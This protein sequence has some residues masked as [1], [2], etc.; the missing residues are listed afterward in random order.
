MKNRIQHSCSL[1]RPTVLALAIATGFP[2]AVSAQ[3][4]LPD[5]FSVI[6]S[7]G[8]D[9]IRL[10]GYY[11]NRVIS[12]D[13]T[14]VIG[15]GRTVDGYYNAFRWTAADG[16]ASLGTLGGNYSYAHSMSA[17]GGVVVG[18]SYL[19]D[20]GQYRA[21]R[22][23]ETA[24]MVDLGTLGGNYS[25]AYGV[26][27][28]GGTVVGE[29][30]IASGH[31]RAFRWTET[32]GMVSL[33]TLGGDYSYAISVSDD[34]NAVAG[35]AHTDVGHG[36]AFRWTEAG[37]MADL[38]TLGGNYSYAYGISGD[39]S[40]VVG[41]SNTE[42][43][44][45]NAFRWT[46]A[47]GMANLGT[48]GGNY[49]YAY[50]VNTDGSVVIGY[51]RT[52]EDNYHAFRWT[53][54]GGMADLGT[55]GGNYSWAS[56]LSDDGS[57]VVGV[58]HDADSQIQPFRWTESTG[59]QSVTD[60]LAGAGVTTPEGWMLADGGEV[61]VNSLGNVLVGT[62]RDA[63][64]NSQVWLA[65]VGHGSGIISVS[66]WLRSVT[67]AGQ[68]FHSGFQLTN[69]PLNGAHHRPLMS[70]PQLGT[71]HCFWAT[72][73]LAYHDNKD[74]QVGTGEIGV[75]TDL[76]GGTVRAGV[77]VG[78]G[79]QDQDLAFGG[80]SKVDGQFLVGE[81]NWRPEGSPVVGSLTAVLGGWDADIRR[82]YMNGATR[83]RSSGSPDVD[84]LALRL[85]A[86]WF[87][88]ARLGS[89]A[90]TPWAS[91]TWSRVEVDGYTES[92]GAF[93]ATFDAQKHNAE[94][95]RVG[96]SADWSLTP[97]T[98]VRGTLEAVHRLDNRGPALSGSEASGLLSFREPGA[99][100]R[101]NWQRVGFDVDHR[102]KSNMVV[103]VSAHAATS[104][105]DPSFSAALSLRVGF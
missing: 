34:G 63:E 2:L 23:T 90:L 7:L 62:G 14:V 25:Y 60:W 57:V 26:S 69:L 53:E 19:S 40:A 81:L 104:G 92:G 29:S 65:R 12:A 70:Y 68:A 78:Y 1:L 28:D 83:D 54:A 37:G 75:C 99:S 20:A 56:G 71:E 15:Y 84:A 103:S 46:E 95:L 36:H 64:G 38:G 52:A 93:P 80:S 43:G 86:D 100:I 32:G 79:R 17:D 39:G 31:Y 27:A 72:G 41:H 61:G 74:A 33:G 94:E 6:G 11:N 49:S 35:Y 45:T 85:R 30:R 18:Y 67:G 5:E 88:A 47:A 82:G 76:A 66:D 3:S 91:Y 44:Y 24:G 87:D 97:E 89:A 48:L 55:L 16:I 101:K 22:W 51:A 96:V 50:R 73:D 4:S 13:G 105:E 77:G 59:M 42:S 58:T 102:I 98:G 9:Y 8:G 10:G 21:F